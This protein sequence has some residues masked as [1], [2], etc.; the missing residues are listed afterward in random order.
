MSVGKALCLNMIVKN[1]M[2]NLRRC[3]DAV[4][5]HIACWVIGDT[6]STDGTQDFLRAYFTERG[7]PGA[8]HSFTFH[9]FEQARNEALERAYASALQYDYLL[10]DDADMELVV[11]D[12]LFRERL[13]APGYRLV[14]RTAGGLSYWNTRLLRRDSSARYRGVTHEYIDI[15]GEVRELQGVWYKDHATGANRSDK[16]ERDIRLLEAALKD[17]PENYRYWFYLAQ[18]FRDAGRTREAADAYARRAGM[19]GW[20]EEAWNA[21]L[22]E[23]RCLLSLGDEDGFLRAALAAFDSRPERAEPLYDLARF[24]RERGKN[25]AAVL[26]AEPG[27]AMVLPTQDV[28]F[29]EDHVYRVG[30]KEEF[31]IVANYAREAERKA[32]GHAVCDWL[33]LSREVPERSRDLARANL[34]FYVEPASTMLPSFSARPV[35]FTPPDNHRP[36]NPS[37]ARLGQ[38]IMLVQRTGNWT[39]TGDGHYQTSDGGPVRT[40]NFL[41]RLNPQLDTESVVEILPPADMPAPLYTQ[42][43]GFEDL[44]LFAWRNELWCS[45]TIRELNPEGWCQQVLA[46]IEHVERGRCQLTDWRVLDS[47]GVVARH[48]KNW[49]PQV[50]GAVLR[51]IYACDPTLVV[52]ERARRVSELVPA[53]AAETFRGGTQAIPFDGGWLA[54]IH[55]VDFR[56]KGRYYQHRLIWFD[57]KNA[58]RRVSRRFVFHMQGIEFAAGIAWH[59]DGT[60][61]L[62]SY[63]REDKDSF[64]ATVDANDIR[65]ALQDLQELLP[66]DFS[67]NYFFAWQGPLPRQQVDQHLVNT[68]VAEPEIPNSWFY[69]AQSQRD[70]V[71]HAEAAATY[72]GRAELGDPDE[73]AWYARVQEA[74]CLRTLG[75]EGGFVRAALAAF[76]QRPQRAEPLYD[77]ARHYR[78]RGMNDASLLFSEPGMAIGW[79]SADSLFVE[80]FVYAAGL[81]EEYSIAANYARNPAR[82]ERGHAVCEWLALSRKIPEHSRNLARRNLV[83]Y[84]RPLGQLAPSLAAHRIGFDPPSGW[85]ACNPGIT[86]WGDDVWC[87]IRTVNYKLNDNGSYTLPPDESFKTRNY[88]ARLDDD[89]APISINELAL[90]A[91]WPK[92]LDSR[93]QGFEDCRL[94]IWRGALWI[95]ATM[96]ELNPEGRC[97]IVL[98]RIEEPAGNPRFTDWRIL[99]PAGPRRDEKNWMPWIDC[100]TLRFV[101]LVDPGRIIDDTARTVHESIPTLALDHLRGGSPLLAFDGGWLAITHEVAILSGGIR[102]YLHRWIWFD[103]VGIVRRVSR[104]FCLLRCEGEFV[105]GL[106]WHIDKKRLVICFGRWDHHE[107]WILTISV[108]DVRGM[109][110]LVPNDG[111]PETASEIAAF[112]AR[113]TNHALRVDAAVDEA[114]TLVNASGWPPA[115]TRYKMW[116]HLLAI[117]HALTMPANAS[118]L[119]AGAD[120]IPLSPF[121]SVLRQCGYRELTG[122]NL[123]LT[124]PEMHDGVMYRHGNITATGFPDGAFDYVA[125]LSVIE[126]GVDVPAFLA[127]MSRILVPGGLLFLSFDYWVDS[128]DTR[129]RI[130]FG[131]PVYIITQQDIDALIGNATRVGLT[132]VGNVDLSCKEKVVHWDGLEYTFGNILFRRG[133]PH[134]ENQ[135]TS[136]RTVVEGDVDLIVQSAFFPDRAYQGTMVEVGAAK[137]S[138]LSVGANFRSRNWRVISIE[139]NPYFCEL[140]RQRGFNIIECACGESDRDNVSFFIVQQANVHSLGQEVTYE[141]F[142]SLGIRGRYADA[143]RTVSTTVDEIKVNVRRLDTIL[144]ENAHDVSE[145]DIV[146]VDVEGWEIEV[147]NGLSFDIYKPKVLIIENLFLEQS[148]RDYMALRNYSLWRRVEWNDIF[149]RNDVLVADNDR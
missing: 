135:A 109:L 139:P 107:A 24:Y 141:S 25:A 51:F 81:R 36:L 105:G 122:I 125:C 104:A 23:A 19:G 101:Y 12:Q 37:I 65:I 83:F 79:P 86:R 94:F 27:L 45:S 67:R 80:D 50:D 134:S 14:Q 110:T 136:L 2:T 114:V 4:A 6:G 120:T 48:E 55:E 17:E 146:S 18:S 66:A 123:A 5:P 9:N 130:A 143:M 116:D 106:A 127:E 89:L 140:H 53:I 56:G 62:I 41:L 96:C 33:A 149:V 108:T 132:V 69:L 115:S 70:A 64:V 103:Q 16:F 15:E 85:S 76:N 145:I 129:S 147:L 49:M 142:S 22:H 30:L 13:N 74:R 144:R 91:D 21:R 63:G 32:R 40:R 113:E 72:A 26:F 78:E 112:L 60:R 52:D 82:K 31:S 131:E 29:L 111:R 75:N 138:Y 121:L 73:E 20:D 68:N 7:I 117:G 128:V 119:D 148:Y 42:V 97:E 133:V 102:R 92:P 95:S 61:L 137:P 59:P 99:T 77:L 93:A 43:L 58:L 28:L 90:P 84:A 124:R 39:V 3:L 1:E 44:R 34:T 126:H 8:L 118:I 87:V 71:R 100:D 47:G 88:L 38:Q 98:A 10:L 54:L 11:E 46:R 35:T 57:W